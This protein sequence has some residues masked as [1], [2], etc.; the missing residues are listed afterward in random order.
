MTESQGMSDKLANHVRQ[1][2]R[3][4]ASNQEED[5]GSGLEGP[6]LLKAWVAMGA[7][8][9]SVPATPSAGAGGRM[10][11]TQNT[12]ARKFEVHVENMAFSRMQ[13]PSTGPVS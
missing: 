13:S 11:P 10:A 12:C 6:P 5:A 2:P 1:Q 8:L 9:H 7:G 3:M 4:E